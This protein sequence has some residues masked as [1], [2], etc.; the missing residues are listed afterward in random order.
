M[1]LDCLINGLFAKRTQLATGAAALGVPYLASGT[2]SYPDSSNERPLCH[3]LLT[4]AAEGS[5]PS[6]Q[7]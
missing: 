1:N 4:A 3:T 7:R 6:E 2:Y 5:V